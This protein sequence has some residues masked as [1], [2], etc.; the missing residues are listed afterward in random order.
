MLLM[1]AVVVSCYISGLH[2]TFQHPSMR[3]QCVV[4]SHIDSGFVHVT[5]LG[6]WDINKRDA[7]ESI[8]HTCILELVL[9]QNSCL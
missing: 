4:L 1:A 5:S 6:R 2:G 8:S 7:S 9:F 3:E